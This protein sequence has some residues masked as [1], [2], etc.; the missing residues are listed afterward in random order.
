MKMLITLF[1]L[2][3]VWWL[4]GPVALAVGLLFWAYEWFGK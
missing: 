1:P 4:F 3:L 2:P